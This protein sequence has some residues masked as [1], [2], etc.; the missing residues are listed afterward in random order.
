MIKIYLLYIF[1]KNI[2]MFWFL[3]HDNNK[4]VKNVPEGPKIR[5][6]MAHKP[7]CY[8]LHYALYPEYSDEYV[9][10]R[11]LEGD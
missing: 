3:P 2:L 9:L 7:L 4:E 6:M 8:Y 5:A 11:V 10:E 1:K